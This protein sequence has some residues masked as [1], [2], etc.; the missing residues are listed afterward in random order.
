MISEETKE[1][2]R[3][4]FDNSRDNIVEEFG[5]TRVFTKRKL[6]QGAYWT[7]IDK[8][9]ADQY[10]RDEK[11]IFGMKVRDELKIIDHWDE[12]M[13]VTKKLGFKT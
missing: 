3:K 12:N 6:T 13:G 2:N 5:S 11:W 4:R 8:D 1:I 9:L 10:I 7:A